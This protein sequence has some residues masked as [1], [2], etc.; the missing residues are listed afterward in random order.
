MKSL[1]AKYKYVIVLALIFVFALFVR[2]YHLN[3]LPADFHEDEVLSGYIGRFI[4]QN[5][6]DIYG[7]KW[8][9]LYF[10][11]FGDYYIILPIYLSG[12][13]TFIFGINAFATRFPAAFLGALAVVP[14]YI[15]AYWIFKNKK[16][17][18]LSALFTAIVPWQLVLARSTTEGVEGSTIF[19]FG[20]VLM[21]YSIR[22]FKIFPLLASAFIFLIG[23]DIYHPFRVYP[24]VVFLAF[25][26]I[27]FDIRTIASEF[28]KHRKYLIIYGILTFFFFVLTA[29]IGTTFWGK[30]RFIE[31]SI[32]SPVS[33]VTITL[34]KLIASEG[35]HNAF[36]ARFFHNKVIG[37]GREF[38][39]QYL[40][41][42]SPVYLF[43]NGWK[44]SRYFVPQQGLL[45]VSFLV[46]LFMSIIPIKK[47]QK[48]QIDTQLFIAL[49][50]LLFLAPIP[51]ALTVVESP[52]VHRS[53]FMSYP[54]VIL[55]AY[56]LYKSFSVGY[57]RISL[58]YC[59]IILLCLEIVNFWHLY[60]TNADLFDSLNRNDGQIQVAL[61]TGEQ[62]KN[63]DAV[64]LPAQ[65]AM[66][67][68]YLFY[69]KDFSPRYI[70]R[71]RLDSRIDKTGNVYYIENSCPS[72]IV[73]KNK[74]PA[75]SLIIDRFDCASDPQYKQLMTMHGVDP[76]LNYK[77]LAP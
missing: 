54:L 73:K 72:T 35:P 60:S 52:N 18:L 13:S 24:P 47:E 7:N 44:N 23:Y 68:Y 69:N 48:L 15:L 70:G 62:R 5:G 74:I 34:N 28:K 67:W 21:I 53:L 61:Y 22:K 51:A 37:Y 11:K 29:Y 12:I 42:F 76:T 1:I 66:S 41:Y 40:T 46:F 26:F 27:F 55:A 75:K 25:I 43:M 39:T 57:K 49:L 9:L 2:T 6:R 3:S 56:G 32:F 33:G 58:S 45:Y 30:G 36:A 10:N 71:F 31:T 50:F 8:P 64:Y 16:I 4:V 14:M 19:L 77:I 38:L 17:G 59:V 63:Y 65:A 20:L